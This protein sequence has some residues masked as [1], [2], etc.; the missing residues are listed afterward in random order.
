MYSNKHWCLY[1]KNISFNLQTRFCVQILDTR[2]IFL[3]KSMPYSVVRCDY[4]AC[5]H[6]LR[7]DISRDIVVTEQYFEK[8]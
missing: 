4:Q 1:V 6:T 7:A 5:Q 8:Y 3:A 2:R